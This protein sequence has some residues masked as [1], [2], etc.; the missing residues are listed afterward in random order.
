MAPAIVPGQLSVAST[1]A[2]AQIQMDGQNNSTWVTPFN[3]TGLNPGQHTRAVGGALNLLVVGVL[4]VG[5][6]LADL[7]QCLAVA[8]PAG[9]DDRVGWKADGLKG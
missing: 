5:D 2:G 6:P 9:V 8:E 7:C 4:Y 3:L 1:P